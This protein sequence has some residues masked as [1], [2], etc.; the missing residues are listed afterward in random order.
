[1]TG[2]INV[3]QVIPTLDEGGAERTV[4]DISDALISAELGSF[5]ATAGGRL[6][7]RLQA[8]GTRLFSLP[9][10][11]KNP[12]TIYRN[13][14]RLAGLAVEH[15]ISIIHA[16]SRAPAWS[17]LFAARRAGCH[18]MTTHHGTFRDSGYVKSLYNSVMARGDVVIANSNFIAQRISEKYPNA[19]GHTLTIARGVDLAEFDRSVVDATRVQAFRQRIGVDDDKRL[20]IL[21][22]RVTPWKGQDVFVDAAARIQ[23]QSLEEKVCFVCVGE[24]EPHSDFGKTLSAKIKDLGLDDCIRFSGHMDDMPAAYAAAAVAVSASTEPEAFGR[25]AVE[26][27]AMGCPIIATALGGSL[28]TIVDG[29]TG[30]LIPPNNPNAL[31]AAITD[32]LAM[33]NAERE[34]MAAAARSNV[35]EHFSKQAMCDKTLAAYRTLAAQKISRPDR[36]PA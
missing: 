23:A 13:I 16:R 32:Y 6:T 28:E 34:R 12:L 9:V 30:H 36:Q 25:I 10:D 18:F 35:T 19:A 20:V 15:D 8:M 14:N 1:M 4:I 17:A 24:A 27:Q 33:S 11:S 22:G 3:L 7:A 31:A 2:R 21:P 29:E 5:V 26:S